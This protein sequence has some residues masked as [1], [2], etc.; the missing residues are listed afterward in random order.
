MDMIEIDGSVGE[1][2]GQVL[3]TALSLSSVLGKGVRI[4]NIRAGRSVPGLRPQHLS[5]CK[6]LCEIAGGK[7]EGAKIGSTQIEF[8]PGKISGGEY[9]F[10][11]GTAGSSVLLSQAVLPVLLSAD[12][13]SSVEITGGTHVRG[14]P[15]FEYFSEVFLP[16]IGK[17]GAGASAKLLRAGFYP[18]GGGV[19]R[20][21]CL[22]S[23]L[24][25]VNFE[26]REARAISY[27]IVS[28][29]LPTHVA[30]REEKALLEK[31]GGRGAAGKCEEAEADCPGN[32]VTVWSGFL[33]ACAL[34]ERGVPAEAVAGKAC[35]ALELEISVGAGVDSHLADQLLAY[36][37]I[38]EGKTAYKSASATSHLKT[39]AIIAQALSG[40]DIILG[41]E[42]NVEVV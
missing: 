29:G 12:A 2:G 17:M 41:S 40:R 1:G 38:A 31:F 3:R 26:P 16:A 6:L 8:T 9:R 14:A 15:S 23:K 37:A 36:A 18:K 32:S 5:V 28:S 39:N 4:R 24:A 19:V 34:G 22:P 7:L 42:C 11:I 25:G 27:S 21:E 20:L 13:P 30:L 35:E 10:D 33:G